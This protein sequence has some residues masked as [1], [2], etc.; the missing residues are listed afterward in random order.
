M[1]KKIA[2]FLLCGLISFS[3][4][5]M[6]VD[7]TTGQPIQPSK[8]EKLK[9]HVK[10]IAPVCLSRGALGFLAGRAVT[11][12]LGSLLRIYH[13][14][15]HSFKPELKSM[16]GL[17]VMSLGVYSVGILHRNYSLNQRNIA[18]QRNITINT[19]IEQCALSGSAIWSFLFGMREGMQ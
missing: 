7:P 3:L 4:I 12:G 5:G 11:G 10:V 9:A 1:F 13:H 14:P 16:A 15:L 2:S 19:S 6:Q 18:M 8:L 17:A